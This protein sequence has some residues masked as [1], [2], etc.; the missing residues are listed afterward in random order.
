MTRTTITILLLA[1]AGSVLSLP[2]ANLADPCGVPD[3]NLSYAETAAPGPVSICSRP[4]GNGQPLSAC[5]LQGGEVTDATITVHLLDGNGMPIAMFPREDIWLDDYFGDLDICGGRFIADDPTDPDGVTTFSQALPAGGVGYGARVIVFGS[6]LN[7]PPLP[8]DFNSPDS[9][10]DLD[11]DLTDR[12]QFMS[13]WV[14]DYHY[15]SDFY[16]DGVIDISDI[17][18]LAQGYDTTCP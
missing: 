15:R 14:L 16:W 2:A 12:V 9:D 8:I 3:L 17:A 1:I 13:D 5:Y 10:G 7:H 18:L 11:V 6:Q 4:D